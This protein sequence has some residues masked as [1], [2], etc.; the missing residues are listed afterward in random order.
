MPY[1]PRGQLSS[2]IDGTDNSGRPLALTGQPRH[3]AVA[4]NDRQLMSLQPTRD[5]T[6]V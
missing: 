1:V 4:G 2:M 3:T 5:A 6:Q